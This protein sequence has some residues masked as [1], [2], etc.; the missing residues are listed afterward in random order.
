M[1]NDKPHK[2][3][4]RLWHKEECGSMGLGYVI[5]G[6]SDGHPDF[7][8]YP[9]HTSYVVKHEG[10]EIETRNSRYTL[11]DPPMELALVP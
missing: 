2:G 10:N 8:G 3:T 7:D 5:C 9:M 11:S 6:L 4:I 1:T